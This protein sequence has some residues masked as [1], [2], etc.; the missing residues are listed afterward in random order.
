MNN[1][2]I[3]E[4]FIM[5]FYTGIIAAFGAMGK[6]LH[7]NV[8]KEANFNFWVFLANGAVGFIIGNIVGGFIEGHEYRDGILWLSGFFY[9][10]VITI[11]EVLL[12]KR[13]DNFIKFRKK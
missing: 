2:E 10:Y 13:L 3:V 4:K 7:D 5:F 1:I 8:I 9:V 11:I 6:Y 12:K